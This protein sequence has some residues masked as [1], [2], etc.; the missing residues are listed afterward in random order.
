MASN[1]RK[2][3]SE[4]TNGASFVSAQRR[5]PGPRCQGSRRARCWHAGMAVRAGAESE[6]E[7]D[8][9]KVVNQRRRRVAKLAQGVSPGKE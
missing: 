2:P 3:A 4:A 6:V 7:N 9:S 1:Q 8:A 5:K